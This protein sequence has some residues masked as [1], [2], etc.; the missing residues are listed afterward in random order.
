MQNAIQYKKEKHASNSFKVEQ[1][2]ASMPVYVCT[3]GRDVYTTG[4]GLVVM[5]ID[6]NLI[7]TNSIKTVIFIKVLPIIMNGRMLW[8]HTQAEEWGI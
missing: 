5:C 3:E 8:H 6:D 4:S 2:S 1:K 7:C